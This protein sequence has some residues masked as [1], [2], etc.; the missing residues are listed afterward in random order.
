MKLMPSSRCSRLQL[1]AHPDPQER[2]ERGERLVEQEDL[3]LGDQRAGERHALLLAAGELGRQSAGI[4][5]HCDELEQFAGTL[6]PDSAVDA[7]HF[8]GK[9]NIVE[10]GQ[11]RK[12]RVRLEHHR[13]TAL[14]GLE[15]GDV[16]RA[17]DDVAFADRLVARDHAQGRSLAAA[18][19]AEQAA[20][21][22]CRDLQI[23]GVDRQRRVVTLGDG[24]QFES[25]GSGHG[26]SGK[27]AMLRLSL[28][29]VRAKRA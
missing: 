26:V 13:R 11:V 10:H 12:Q 17:K 20:I 5:A 22:A 24:D 28:R 23:D 29:K 9:R 3:R 16:L 1:A 8:Q 21:G 2:I 14:G 15:V 27:R 18:G 4:G 6:V 19:G 25:G 7:A